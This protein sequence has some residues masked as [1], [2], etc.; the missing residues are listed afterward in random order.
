MQ[1]SNLDIC[2]KNYLNLE[3]HNDPVEKLEAIYIKFF[4]E[5]KSQK[6]FNELQINSFV[7]YLPILLLNQVKQEK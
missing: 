1:A 6:S 3:N 4:Y 5:G 7:L 2:L